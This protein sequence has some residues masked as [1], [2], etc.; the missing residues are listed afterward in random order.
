MS[1]LRES[2]QRLTS[3]QMYLEG[4]VSMIFSG[5]H[6]TCVIVSDMERS[7]A[8]Y[9]DTLGMQ[10]LTN[11]KYD[12]DPVMMDLQGT[13]P[14]Q[15]LI[16]LS[17]GNTIIELI[18]YIEPKGKPYDRRPCDIS[19]MHIAFSVDDIN[20]VYEELKAKGIR[21]HRDPDII[22]EGGGNLAGFGYVYF[23]GPDNEILELIEPTKK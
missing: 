7:L 8:F 3:Y 12:A 10:E 5:V 20:K 11:L 9:R 21:F 18:Q 16:M 17:A 6:H 1:L 4:G 2:A 14:K 13:E 15:H 22:G 19:N 23:R